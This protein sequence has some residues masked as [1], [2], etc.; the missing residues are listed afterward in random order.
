MSS[1]DQ[2]TEAEGLLSFVDSSP[3]PYH[4]SATAARMLDEAGWKVGS[5]GIRVKNGQRFSV[6]LMYAADD[7]LR[8]DLAVEFSAQMKKLGLEFPLEP[9]TYDKMTPQLPN[10]ACVLGGGSSPYD[11][12]LLIYGELH[13][14]TKD[15]T[16]YNNPGNYGGATMDAL[17]EAA[18]REMDP[19]K[20]NAAYRAVMAEYVK[21]PNFVYLAAVNHN[22]VSRP[23]AWKKGGFVLE[24]H[25]HGATWGPWWNLAAWAK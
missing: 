22:Y 19:G 11:P 24:P 13:S 1:F 10:K 18:R 4:A 20:R 8:R 7:S 14:R 12:D 5:D 21:N 16:P 15:S 23:N 17:L 6:P 25:V 9:G 2:R 3:S